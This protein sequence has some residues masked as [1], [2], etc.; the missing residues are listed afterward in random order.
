MLEK[1]VTY[2]LG[3]LCLAFWYI[4]TCKYAFSINPVINVNY[5]FGFLLHVIFIRIYVC[6]VANRYLWY[7]QIHMC[8]IPDE[9]CNKYE[10]EAIP[11]LHYRSVYRPALLIAAAFSG[12]H[13]RNINLKQWKMS[14]TRTGVKWLHLIR[15]LQNFAERSR[16]FIF[17]NK[18]Y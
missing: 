3:V 16:L 9:I 18:I 1:H 14:C 6:T 4:S 2:V 8:F 12:Q 5:Q 7:Q 10:N 17:Y 11:K 15:P 13:S